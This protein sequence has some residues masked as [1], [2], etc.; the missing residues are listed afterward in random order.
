LSDTSLVGRVLHTLIGYSDHPTALQGLCYVATLVV[1]ALLMK[2]FAH[3]AR[4]AAVA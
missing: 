1:I 2:L 3:P 4:R